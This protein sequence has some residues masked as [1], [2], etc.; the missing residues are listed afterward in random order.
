MGFNN[1][2]IQ[3]LKSENCGYYALGLLIYINKNLKTSNLFKVANDYVDGFTDDTKYNDKLLRS[4]YR[5]NTQATI[6]PLVQ[7]LLKQK[8]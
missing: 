4:F 8:K 7:R 3:D 6:P 2:I 1:W 5:E